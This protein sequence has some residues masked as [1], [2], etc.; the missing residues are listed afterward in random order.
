M[1]AIQQSGEILQTIII[2]LSMPETGGLKMIR[3][4]TMLSASS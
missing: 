1:I 3:R 4:L 2:D